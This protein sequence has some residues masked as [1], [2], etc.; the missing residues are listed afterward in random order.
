MQSKYKTKA[1]AQPLASIS[2][3]VTPVSLL[4]YSLRSF[5]RIVGFIV[6]LRTSLLYLVLLI[7]LHCGKSASAF[8]VVIDSA[9]GFTDTNVENLGSSHIDSGR[10]Q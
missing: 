3:I 9:F 4:L 6:R 5:R 7:C 8:Q 1:E 10:K 2:L